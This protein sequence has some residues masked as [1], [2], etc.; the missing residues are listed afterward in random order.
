MPHPNHDIAALIGAKKVEFSTRTGTAIAESV[1][2]GKVRE[3]SIPAYTR[4]IDHFSTAHDHIRSAAAAHSM[5]LYDEA[6]K[7]MDNAD[8]E[9]KNALLTS[10]EHLGESDR[11][12]P[13]LSSLYNVQNN[14]TNLYRSQLNLRDSRIDTNSRFEE[15][16]KNENL[17]KQFE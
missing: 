6:A 17:G 1:M 14:H 12:T 7:S 15:M 10:K 3:A 16:M 11:L 5:G 8:Q 4:V 9:F 13:L 2:G